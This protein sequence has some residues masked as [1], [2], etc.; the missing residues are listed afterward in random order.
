[1]VDLAPDK[2]TDHLAE[3][4]QIPVDDGFGNLMLTGLKEIRLPE[5]VSWWPQAP[6]WKYLAIILL[7]LGTYSLFKALKRWRKNAYRRVAISQLTEI[8]ARGVT[9]ESAYQL[10]YLIKATALRVYP[11]IEIA[12]LT[13]TPWFTYLN[14][15]SSKEYFDDRCAE[16]L[17]KSRYSAKARKLSQ[18]DFKHLVS[19]TREW[20]EQHQLP[21]V[22]KG[23]RSEKME[24]SNV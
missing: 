4:L 14:K 2:K 18:D 24:L 3:A 5:T 8:S 13:G 6:G 10:A 20:V 15:N 16:L 9:E 1:M 21:E 17:G 19:S 7:V 11:R 22:S 12:A 23:V